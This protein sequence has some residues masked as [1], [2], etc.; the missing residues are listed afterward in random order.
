MARRGGGE[1]LGRRCG[2]VHADT[3]WGA[4]LAREAA[5]TWGP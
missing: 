4:G 2:R 5:R 1:G 3:A